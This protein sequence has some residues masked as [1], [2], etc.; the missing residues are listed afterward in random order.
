MSGSPRPL[1]VQR[2]T[3]KTL[4]THHTVVFMAMIFYS[5]RLQSK[6]S[7]GKRLM[8][9]RPEGPR[10]QLP[11]GVTQARLNSPAMSCEPVKCCLPGRLI[12]DSVPEVFY[13]GW[14]HRNLL[15]GMSQIPPKHQQVFSINNIVC[16]NSSGTVS[17][18]G[19]HSPQ[20]EVPR[21]QLRARLARRTF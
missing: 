3:R 18:Y 6:I 9:Q 20:I 7:K 5:K 13:W 16:T 2:F 14:S 21:C 12:S 11:S 19:G 8:K 4:R 15:P 17:H 1:P 10:S